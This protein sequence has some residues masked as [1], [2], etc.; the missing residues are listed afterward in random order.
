MFLCDVSSDADIDA[1]FIRF[2][3]EF[4]GLDFVVHGAAFALR[5]ELFGSFLD[6]S[7]D[8][9]R[10]A[11]DVLVYSLIALAKRAVRTF[12]PDGLFGLL[13]SSTAIIAVSFVSATA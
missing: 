6:I 9:F 1:V 3:Q 12:G 4:G 2:D 5:D 13:A 7:R 8:G 11:L 10:V